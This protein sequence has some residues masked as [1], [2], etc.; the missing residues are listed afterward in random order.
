VGGG[1][2]GLRA[3][4]WTDD[5]FMALCLAESLLADPGLSARDLMDRFD[6]WLTQGHN[7]STGRCFD[8]GHT[9]F[10]A[11][12]RYRRT[13]DPLAGDPSPRAAGN[14]SIMRLAPVA[15][16][17]WRD[18]AT[19]EAVARR[20]GLTTHAAPEAVDACALLARML[21]GAIAGGGRGAVLAPRV[22]PG[23]RPSI[24]AIA[25]GGWRGRAE[26][27]VRSTG[28]VVHTLEAAVWAFARAACCGRST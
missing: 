7:S 6:R 19:A 16:R 10:A 8:I 22:D 12:E 2:F 17:W 14:G 23:W 11:I 18:P 24:R 5:T 28:Y 13:G 21:V 3:G 27:D 1:L 4:Q 15:L 26:A 25:A 20:Q 9:T